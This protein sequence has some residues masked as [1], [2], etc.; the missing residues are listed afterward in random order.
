MLYLRPCDTETLRPY[1]NDKLYD[2]CLRRQQRCKLSFRPDL[3]SS[4]SSSS[5]FFFT[6]STRSSLLA[7]SLDHADSG[8]HISSL[9]LIGIYFALRTHMAFT[10]YNRLQCVRHLESAAKELRRLRQ[11]LTAETMSAVQNPGRLCEK[12]KRNHGCPLPAGKQPACSRRRLLQQ[13]RP[14]QVQKVSVNKVDQKQR[15][16]VQMSVDEID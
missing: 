13:Q 8:S 12:A 10:S 11:E 3:S 16:E 1:D 9:I 15:M 5:C 7:A 2:K 14:N 4:P 6:F